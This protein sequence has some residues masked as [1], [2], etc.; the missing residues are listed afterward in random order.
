MLIRPHLREEVA[1]TAKRTFPS[2]FS[3]RHRQGSRGLGVVCPETEAPHGV[4]RAGFSQKKC[5][6]AQCM[7][8]LHT[9]GV[10][11]APL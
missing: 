7:G 2:N 3:P 1:R 5:V 8:V 4:K 9:F 6:S 11:A 10:W